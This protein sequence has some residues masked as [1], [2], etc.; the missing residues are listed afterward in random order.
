VMNNRALAQA[1]LG[2]FLVTAGAG[3]LTTK[4]R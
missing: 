2:A 1:A 3:H 4:R